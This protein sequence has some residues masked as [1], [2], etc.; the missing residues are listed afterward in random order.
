LANLF[1][2]ASRASARP[3]PIST[4]GHTRRAF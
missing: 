2:T 1:P 4:F 3:A